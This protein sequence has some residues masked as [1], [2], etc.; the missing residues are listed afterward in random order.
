MAPIRKIFLL[1][2]LGCAALCAAISSDFEKGAAQE[3]PKP[4]FPQYAQM[5]DVTT[6]PD[7]TLEELL[8]KARSQLGDEKTLAAVRA[9]EYVGQVEEADGKL[10]ANLR[11]VYEKPY[12]LRRQETQTNGQVG[13]IV[14]DEIDGWMLLQQPGGELS[15]R[16]M[17]LNNKDFE[18]NLAVDKLNFFEG[19]KFFDNGELRF[20]GIVQFGGKK[21]YRVDYAYP[22]VLLKMV[23]TR[24]FDAQTGRQMALISDRGRTQS[25]DSGV[26]EKDGIKFPKT[27]TIY[28]DGNVSMRINYEDIIVNAQYPKTFFYEP[29]LV[30]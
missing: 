19:P 13:A 28:R 20:I 16:S 9:L 11:H 29:K 3:K 24:I 18:R 8:K 7:I 1:G 26:L 4:A 30:D 17:P 23:L 6:E 22:Y 27:T 10:R 5:P 2:T 21:A 12:K 15:K 14:L 25:I